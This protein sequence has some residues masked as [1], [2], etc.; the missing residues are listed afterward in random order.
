[1]IKN[2]CQHCWEKQSNAGRALDEGTIQA[3]FICKKCNT[4]MTAS[5]VFQLETFTHLKGFQKWLSIVAIIIS[6]AALV[7]AFIK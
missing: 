5:E 1:M 2:E 7:V 3:T 6:V 4:E